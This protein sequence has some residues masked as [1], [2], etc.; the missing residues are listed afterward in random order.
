[1]IDK[2]PSQNDYAR[3]ALRFLTELIAWVGAPWALWP[4]STALA[5]AARNR[6][7]GG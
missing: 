6:G 2:N 5:I 7:V 1:M 3:G 4:H